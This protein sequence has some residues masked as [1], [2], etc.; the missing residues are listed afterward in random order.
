MGN[1]PIEL[2][3]EEFKEPKIKTAVVRLLDLV[4]RLYKENE[5]LKKGNQELKDEI[6]RLKGEQ[7]KPKIKGKTRTDHSSTE[8]LKKQ[9]LEREKILNRRKKENKNKKANRRVK[10]TIDKNL[11]PE[12][13]KFKGYKYN[14]VAEIKIVVENILYQ[15]EKYYS[16]SEKKTYVAPLP[17]GCS[18]DFGASVR[19]FVIGLTQSL[20][21]TQ[22]AMKGFLNSMGLKISKAEIAR[23]LTKNLNI[24]H[25]EKLEIAA[26]GL[27]LRSY[28]Q[29]DDTKARVKGQNFHTHI[30]CNE[31]FT[32]FFTEKKKDRRTI[33]D[34]LRLKKPRN[35][36]INPE[37]LELLE[38]WSLPDKRIS[39]LTVYQKKDTYTEEAFE[40]IMKA[41]YPDKDKLT[42]YQNRIWEAA[43]IAAYHMEED[44]VLALVSDDAPQ[45]QYVTPFQVLCWIH[46][47]RHYKKLMPII[48]YHRMELEWF[49][50]QFWLFYRQLLDYQ[51]SPSPD[52]VKEIENEFD[53]L[54][55]FKATY[56]ELKDR[57]EKTFSNKEQLLYVLKN[58]YVPLHN[59]ISELAARNKVRDRDVR[60]H[61]MSE[62]GTMANDTFLT[63]MDTAR[64][65]GVCFLKYIYDRISGEY[66]LPSLAS[67]VEQSLFLS[68]TLILNG[69][70]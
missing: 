55:Q 29:T 46:E 39:E 24:F 68:K 34:V 67:L 52:R 47:G 41:L 45:F 13:A 43:Y 18:R 38:K 30:L 10:C 16:K 62:E 32:A 53:T 44:C 28:T 23:M 40:K 12:D 51:D 11:L 6:N 9:K 58:P 42:N 54:C 20:K 57:M 31:Q 70:K 4:E 49:S 22:S 48:P 35:Y 1:I 60:F 50:N 3:L 19:A 21:T 65:Q 59:N 15:R 64:K 7:G 36:L 14:V 5:D 56:S 26:A 27:K 17:T 63:L 8:E 25:S 69:T 61:T 33:V 66:N 2:N 37:T